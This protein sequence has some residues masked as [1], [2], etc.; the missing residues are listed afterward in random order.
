HNLDAVEDSLDSVLDTQTSDQMKKLERNINQLLT[1]IVSKGKN[2]SGDVLKKLMSYVTQMMALV[3]SVMART[4]QKKGSQQAR[5]GNL[6]E[7]LYQ[8]Q[9]VKLRHTYNAINYEK[10]VAHAMKI[11]S[12][13]AKVVVCVASLALAAVTGGAAS[14]VV[15]LLIT[16]VMASGVTDKLTQAVAKVM[17]QNAGGNIAADLV[18]TTVTMVATLGIGAVTAIAQVGVETAVSF[19]MS[20]MKSAVGAVED[21]AEEAATNAA[22]SAADAIQG[23]DQAALNSAKNSAKTVAKTVGKAAAKA[24]TRKM[25]RRLLS[26]ELRSILRNGTVK[27]E[28]EG[29]VEKAVRSARNEINEAAT[30]AARGTARNAPEEQIEDETAAIANRAERMIARTLD[31]IDKTTVSGK[32]SLVMS[33]LVALSSTNILGDVVGG[34]IQAA[35]GK[36]V[37]KKVWYQV[38]KGIMQMIQMILLS[39]AMGAAAKSGIAVVDTAESTMDSSNLFRGASFVTGVGLFGSGI[40]DSISGGE[41]IQ[42]AGTTESLGRV[43]T[44]LHFLRQIMDGL[45]EIVQT[46]TDHTHR[47]LSTE[48]SSTFDII[49]AFNA[50]AQGY[51][52]VLAAT[53]V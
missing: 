9:T 30:N 50:G 21:A 53:A 25:A 5:I 49:N 14:F 27:K 40:A 2:V 20:M 1:Q 31:H 13:V 39:L 16:I 12:I 48:I 45:N 42:Q 37:K 4:D 38:V 3:Q 23:A 10:H 11:F 36:D 28:M 17:P 41:Q 19:A 51:A 24:A 15:A 46:E 35:D 6:S 43:N 8:L 29:A 26:R 22:R 18:T 52:N 7:S 44:N 47:A 33:G 34:I 32:G